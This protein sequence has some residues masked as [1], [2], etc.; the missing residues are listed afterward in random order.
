ME[1]PPEAV[2]ALTRRGKTCLFES[3]PAVSGAFFSQP[4]KVSCQLII[5]VQSLPPTVD[6]LLY[7][8]R[9]FHDL[10]VSSHVMMM[11]RI[12]YTQSCII[13]MQMVP[14]MYKSRS[15]LIFSDDETQTLPLLCLIVIIH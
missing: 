6:E 11:N 4:V 5:Q 1:H 9:C 10:L 15:R 2:P 7:Y 13:D 8:E 3:K 12:T 14:A